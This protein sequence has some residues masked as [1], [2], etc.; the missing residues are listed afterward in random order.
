MGSLT[1]KT[2]FVTA[3]GQGIGLA[4]AR[5]LARAGAK[6]HAT[7]I[8]GENLTAFAA[9]DG[10]IEAHRLDV[11]NERAIAD[12]VSGIG[13]IDIL[14]N[15]AGI[16]HNGTVLD[17]KDDEIDLAM[18]LNVKAMVRTIRAVLP[19]MLKQGEGSIINMASVVSSVKGAPNRCVYGLTKAAVIGLTKSVAADYVDR[20]IRCNAICPGTVDSPSLRQRL[21]ATGDYAAAR[22]AFIARQQMG[23]LGTSE[24][25][26][27]LVVHL[28]GAT[29]TTGQTCI[30]DGG[31][32]I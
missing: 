17:A 28:A 29:Y 13:R 5:A 11:R 31:W 8:N 19:A 10:S 27:D 22:K 12:L 7:D 25:I 24:E 18:D 32:T 2:A 21:E 1:G 14:F 30:I 26:A 3:A 6:V 20:G 23:R 15:C 4:S 9:E 16:V